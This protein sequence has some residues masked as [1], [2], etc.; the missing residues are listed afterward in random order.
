[1]DFSFSEEQKMLMKS[2]R[3]FLD[4][5][6]KKSLVKEMEKDELGFS[7]ELWRQI[8]GLGWLGLVF[9]EQFGGS[10]MSFLDLAALL[11]ETG[12]ACLPGPFFSS[13]VL[14]GLTILDA[15]TEEQKQAYLTGISRGESYFTLA[16]TESDGRYDVTSIKLMAKKVGTG[17][18]L[19][20]SKLFVPDA[21]IANHIICVA[22]TENSGTPE[23]GIS[24]FII[25]RDSPGIKYYPL[26]TIAGDKQ[27]EVVF[28]DVPVASDRLLGPLNQGWPLVRRAIER[29][30]VAKCCEMVGIMQRTLEMTVDYAKDRKQFGHPIGSLQAIQHH[31]ANM[32]SDVDGTRFSTYQAAWKL[33]EGLDATIEVAVAKAWISEAFSRVITLAHQVHGAI[34]CTLDHELQYYTRRG[35]QGELFYGDGEYYREIVARGMGL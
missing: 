18:I 8:A 26:E 6:C 3:D 25:D 30:A 23:N 29:A 14:S 27:F 7:P 16:V 9:P 17:F 24:L 22:R 21:H 15:G 31:C 5:N 12:R 32:A 11:E 10:N 34:G 20:G 19:N 33:S 2:A 13:V 28:Q 35:K 4:E 1:M